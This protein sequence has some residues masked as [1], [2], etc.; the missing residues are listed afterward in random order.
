MFKLLRC[1]IGFLLLVFIPVARL[2]ADPSLVELPGNT[3]DSSAVSAIPTLQPPDK[4]TLPEVVVSTNRLDTPLSQVA[5]SMSIITAK[6][7]ENKQ[8]GT[9]L[10]ALQGVPGLTLLQNGAPGENSSIFI[11]GA[12]ASHTLVLIDG[13]PLNNPISTDREFSNFDQYFLND[14]SQIEVVRGP[15]STVYG[16]N[17]TAGVVNIITQQGDGTPKGSIML[18]GG[19]YNSFR[20]TATAFAGNQGINYALSASRF[21]TD[22]FPS[23]DQSFGNTVNNENENT[24]ASLRVG[25]L[26]LS[27]E[28]NSFYTR[29]IQTRTNLPAQGGAGGDDPNYFLNE[30]Q[31]V[32]GSQSKWRLLGDD[33]EQVLG[34]SYT[35]D[36]QQYT[37]D[38]SSYI[39]SHFERGIFEGQSAQIN[40]QNNLQL[41][42]GETMVAGIQAQQE[43]GREDDTTDYGYG[44]SEALINQTTTT[45]SYFVESQTALLDRLFA[46]LGGR[47]DAVSSFGN[48]ITYRG[49]VAYFIPGLETKLKATYGTGFTAPSIYQLY[50]PYGNTSLEAETSEG[51]DIGFEQPFL[52]GVVETG[53]T[54]F[55]NNFTNLIN[56]ESTA[57]PPYGQYFNVGTAQAEGWETF[58][59]AKPVQDLELRADYTYT[60]AFDP[61]WVTDGLTGLQLLRRPQ[62]QADF[63]ASYQWRG[64]HLGFNVLYVGDRPDVAFVNFTATPVTL[65]S[66]TLVNL[67]ASYDVSPNIKFFGRVDNLFNTIYEEVYGYGTPGVS[68]YLGTKISL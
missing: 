47:L 21:E 7:I 59:S 56:F 19:A 54:Y 61:N 24:T 4:L 29:Y 10:D 41:W 34:I 48:Q 12:D 46:T 60:W 13:M 51:W 15:L 32:V 37:D 9:V 23:A 25:F 18:E 20:E 65:P 68:V 31:W 16:T 67:M 66:Y 53:A 44:P 2:L 17:A 58:V 1:L 38:F 33:W 11:R 28:D 40:W 35:D 3:L 5:N 30:H 52:G 43:W 42:K 8:A 45:G 64:A 49:A 62:N 55:N 27:N 50:S 63:S 36:L 26:P 22:G 39:N 6:D 57:T 14:V